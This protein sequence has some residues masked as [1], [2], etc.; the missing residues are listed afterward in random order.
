LAA[1]SVIVTFSD[2][3]SVISP[4]PKKYALAFKL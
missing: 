1:I 3:W 4:V 2:N